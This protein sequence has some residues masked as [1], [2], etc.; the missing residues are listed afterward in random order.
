MGKTQLFRCIAGLRVTRNPHGHR[1]AGR[2]TGKR[3]HRPVGL[4]LARRHDGEM[5]GAVGEFG[6]GLQPGPV[7][8]EDHHAGLVVEIAVV[9]RE[10]GDGR[11]IAVHRMGEEVAVA[12]LEA[13]EGAVPEIGLLAGAGH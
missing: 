6:A 2:R 13:V 1:L 5:Q 10:F 9:G 11:E 7:V 8:D 3:H 4:I 12:M